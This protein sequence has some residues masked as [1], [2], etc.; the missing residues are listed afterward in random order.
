MP[1]FQHLSCLRQNAL[2]PSMSTSPALHMGLGMRSSSRKNR[3][4]RGE[5]E[6]RSNF[7]TILRLLTLPSSRTIQCPLL[8]QIP[9]DIL[10]IRKVSAPRPSNL[11]LRSFRHSL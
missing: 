4:R 6:R 3:Y 9:E 7:Q 1:P 2:T 8:L 10:S 5:D 11:A